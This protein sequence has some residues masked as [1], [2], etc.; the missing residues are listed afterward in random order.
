MFRKV[1]TKASG[2]Q[3]ELKQWQSKLWD[4]LS[5]PALAIVSTVRFGLSYWAKG[6]D[7][8]NP[9]SH[10][11]YIKGDKDWRYSIWLDDNVSLTLEWNKRFRTFQ[12]AKDNIS[13]TLWKLNIIYE[14]EDKNWIYLIAINNKFPIRF[15]NKV[16]WPLDGGFICSMMV[17]WKRESF[18]LPFIWWIP[19]ELLN[20]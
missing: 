19:E 15:L 3:V 5:R 2:R 11:I 17:N 14:K 9:I 13:T 10:Y 6:K 20:L 7:K 12:E 1:R 8:K 4:I 18:W 16:A